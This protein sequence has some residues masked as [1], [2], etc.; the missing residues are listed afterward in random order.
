MK[1]EGSIQWYTH[2]S[3]LGGGPLLYL[4][5]ACIIAGWKGGG[6]KSEMTLWYS[7]VA[8]IHASL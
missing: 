4:L 5:H 6:G 2:P 1:H 7:V 3:L 8:Y